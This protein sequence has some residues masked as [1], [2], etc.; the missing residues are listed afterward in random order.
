MK[1]KLIST[2]LLLVTVA[3]SAL[4]AGDEGETNA[5]AKSRRL[6]VAPVR[7]LPLTTMPTRPALAVN[8]SKEGS[9][10]YDSAMM[11]VTQRF[12]AMLAAIAEAVKGGEL[13]S[14][15]A[16]EM[17]VEQYQLAHMQ[18]ELLSL[19]REIEEQDLA[20]SPDA[21]TKPDLSQ[22]NEIVMVKLPFSSLQVNKSLSAYL[23]L[24]P[25]QV[26]AIQQ[27]LIRQRK[28]REPLKNAATDYKREAGCN[29]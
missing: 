3:P 9:L 18:F 10:D 12:S 8:E 7:H 2:A 11:V 15:Q 16:M 22:E 28:N 17:S 19:W 1:P 13:S 20:G 27:I 29:W 24:T 6:L 4:A 25:S 14:E 23:S 26:E 21:Q 5:Q